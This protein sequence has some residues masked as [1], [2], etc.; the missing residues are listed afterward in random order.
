MNDEIK[1]DALPDD[2]PVYL[3]YMYVTDDVAIISNIQ[4]TVKELKADLKRQGIEANNIYRY[5]F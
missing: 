3:D 2:Y 5:K 4:G 1:T